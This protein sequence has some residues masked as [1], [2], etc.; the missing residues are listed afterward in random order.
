M[1]KASWSKVEKEGLV[2]V[3]GLAWRDGAAEEELA[4]LDGVFEDGCWL[5]EGFGVGE[6]V[7]ESFIE[8][9]KAE[10]KIEGG[11]LGQGARE[12]FEVAAT[13]VFACGGEVFGELGVWQVEDAPGEAVIEALLDSARLEGAGDGGNGEVDDFAGGDFF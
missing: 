5:G 7:G 6:V 13:D 3:V 11:E 1:K 8:E 10:G 9:G 4:G 12:G 2:V